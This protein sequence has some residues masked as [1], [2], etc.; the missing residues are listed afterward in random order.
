MNPEWVSIR[1]RHIFFLQLNFSHSFS[2]SD[3]QDFFCHRL[4]RKM[5]LNINIVYF[6]DQ[7]TS[8]ENELREYKADA[9]RRNQL[10]RTDANDVTNSNSISNHIDGTIGTNLLKEEIERL[11]GG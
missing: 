8:L 3:S 11:K 7:V 1:H 4:V 5:V 10:P 2:C 9:D 6:T